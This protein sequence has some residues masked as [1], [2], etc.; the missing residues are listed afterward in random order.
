[1]L[2]V[3]ISRTLVSP[4]AYIPTEVNILYL[5]NFGGNQKSCCTSTQ[6][7]FGR[8]HYESIVFA[9]PSVDTFHRE[10]LDTKGVCSMFSPWL[11][12]NRR[13]K[14]LEG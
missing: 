3:H 13:A 12:N 1:M 2:P 4:C 5:I 7:A 10:M 14:L 11:L 9:S 8:L 6:T